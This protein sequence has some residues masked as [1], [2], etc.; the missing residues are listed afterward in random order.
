MNTGKISNTGED[1]YAFQRWAAATTVTPYVAPFH[2]GSL[3]FP[4]LFWADE[5]CKIVI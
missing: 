2:A 3:D 1:S 5:L 4:P